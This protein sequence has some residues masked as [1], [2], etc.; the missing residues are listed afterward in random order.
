MTTTYYL[1]RHQISGDLVILPDEEARHAIQVLRG[2]PGDE[3][4]AVDGEGGWYRIQLTTLRKRHAEGVILEKKQN[5]GEPGYNLT[6]AVALLK[7]QKR[8]DFI[9]EKASE[10]GVS[11]LVPLITARTEKRNMRTRRVEN[12]LVA[13]MKQC[14]RS[15]LVEVTEVMAWGDCLNLMPEAHR[16]LCHEKTSESDRLHNKLS[17]VSQRDDLLIGIGPEGGFS[18]DEV[19]D[20][21]ASGFKVASLGDRRLRAETAAISACAGVMLRF[22]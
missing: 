12:V 18:E 8:F 9:V 22:G 6:L 14:G 21:L 13:A 1:P 3:I 17:C 5:V 16:Y 10:L 7:N 15:R 2:K 19:A 20:A 4:V 11:R